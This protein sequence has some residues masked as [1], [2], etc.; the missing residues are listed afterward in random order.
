MSTNTLEIIPEKTIATISSRKK[1]STEEH[2][3]EISIVETSKSETVQLSKSAMSSDNKDD[4]RSSARQQ[5]SGDQRRD[6]I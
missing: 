4:E 2:D 3:Q 1:F 5:V 6:I